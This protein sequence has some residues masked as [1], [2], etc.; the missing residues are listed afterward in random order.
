MDAWLYSGRPKVLR[1]ASCM[2]WPALRTMWRGLSIRW[3]RRGAVGAA[4]SS[5][6]DG[7]ADSGAD[8]ASVRAADCTTAP[9][10]HISSMMASE[11]V[12]SPGW[13]SSCG[14]LLHVRTKLSLE[15]HH[16]HDPTALLSD[17]LPS[18]QSGHFTCLF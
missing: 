16:G 17:S 18:C 10:L 8:R 12:I 15:M 13:V 9:A 11:P 1:M 2:Y 4:G 6:G 14:C 5:I 3:T 7:A